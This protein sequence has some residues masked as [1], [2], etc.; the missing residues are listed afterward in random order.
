MTQAL[1]FF[2]IFAVDTFPPHD[3]PRFMDENKLPYICA[4]C[5]SAAPTYQNAWCAEC[6]KEQFRRLRPFIDE[7][8]TAETGVLTDKRQPLHCVA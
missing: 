5:G 3:F 1:P 6:L 8:R 7:Q 2:T 4:A